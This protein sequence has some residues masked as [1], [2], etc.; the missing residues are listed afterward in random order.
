MNERPV[1]P[2]TTYLLDNM[3]YGVAPPSRETLATLH[4]AE[5]PDRKDSLSSDETEFA[6]DNAK[7]DKG[8]NACLIWTISVVAFLLLVVLGLWAWRS[9][10]PAES[11]VPG[12]TGLELKLT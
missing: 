4:E 9:G 7:N 11:G 5:K 6:E 3:W 2:S 12:S 1:C 8:S 10:A